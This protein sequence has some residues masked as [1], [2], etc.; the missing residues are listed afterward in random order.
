MRA[1]LLEL[2]DSATVFWS[3]EAV[4]VAAAPEIPW[5]ASRLNAGTARKGKHRLQG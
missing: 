5:R 4:V 1:E 2:A 3:L